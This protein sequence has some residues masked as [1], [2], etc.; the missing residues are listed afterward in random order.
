M[1]RTPVLVKFG[2][3]STGLRPVARRAAGPGPPSRRNCTS[4]RTP[5]GLALLVLVGLVG[6]CGGPHATLRRALQLSPLTPVTPGVVQAAAL[7][8]FPLGSPRARVVRG[9]PPGPEAEYASAMV[10]VLRGRVSEGRRI[11]ARALGSRDSAAMPESIRGLMIAGDGWAQLLQ[12]DSAGGISRMRAGLDRSAAPNEETA[13]ARLQ[14]ALNLAA[15]SDT[16]AEG[17]SWLRYGFDFLPLYK[18]LTFLA[19]G[20]AYEA[21]GVRDSATQAYTHFL[22]LWDKADP[23]LQGRVREARSALEELNREPR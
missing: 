4:T 13:F 2:K 12:G 9:L 16:R 18:P 22:R 10:D 15:R 20:H 17:I 23:E 6:G 14:L 3:R 5:V 21:A 1:N 11:L 7:K 8:R 19:L